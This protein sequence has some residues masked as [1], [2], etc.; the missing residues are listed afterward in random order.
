MQPRF[1]GQLR[2]LIYKNC[3]NSHLVQPVHLKISGG[4]YL[5]PTHQCSGQKCGIGLCLITDTSYKCLC[6]ETDYH[7]EH[8]EHERKAYELTFN[9]KNYLRYNLSQSI[10]SL[11]EIIQLQFKTNHYN[12]LL[13]QLNKRMMRISLKQ[14]QIA[15]EC[16]FNHQW[17]EST[18]KDLYLIDNQWHYVQIKR[19]HG[20]IT[21]MIDEHHLQF[22]T[23]I[24]FDYVVNL[25]DIFIAGNNKNELLKNFHGCL[26][27]ISLVT[28]DSFVF[29]ISDYFLNQQAN[30]INLSCSSLLNP[31]EFLIPLSFIS[32]E[33]S[34]N[35][36]QMNNYQLNISFHFQTYSSDAI[37]LYSNNELN[38]NFLGFDLIDGFLYLTINLHQ[39]K[40]RQ[41]LFQQ[42][43]NNGQTHFIDLSAQGY[44]GGL[45]LKLTMNH[46]QSTR[47]IIRG[48]FSKI[49]VSHE[50]IIMIFLAL[51]F[52]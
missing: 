26:K 9:G 25:T 52:Y 16:Y 30:K 40:R 46:R 51:L 13:F 33:L 37:I 7:G 15:I 32:F 34:E 19:K 8:C 29:N 41:E 10:L 21:M 36:Q 47:I 38:T 5:T 18:T 14:G 27:D 48:P 1:R 43:L 3:T 35:I 44:Q 28:N 6:D 22:E 49:H 11:N 20:Q 4:V 2:N 23:D 42:R 24:E 50:E 17:Y 12:G 31:I 39:A 45:E